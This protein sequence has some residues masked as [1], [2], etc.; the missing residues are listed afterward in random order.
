MIGVSLQLHLDLLTAGLNPMQTKPAK[1][2]R[3]YLINRSSNAVASPL[4]LQTI[5]IFRG[6]RV[7]ELDVTSMFDIS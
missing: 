3:S 6:P 2:Y 5:L 7:P 4:T 1:Q